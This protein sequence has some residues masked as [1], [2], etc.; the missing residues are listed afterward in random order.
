MDSTADK[1]CA[2]FDRTARDFDAIYTGQ[3]SS[4]ARWMD[5]RFRWDM[6]RRYE[7]T[8]D[9]ARDLRA[10]GADTALDVGCGSGRFCVA[11]GAQQYRRILGIDF[12]PA[13]I[14][15]AHTIAEQ[16]QVTDRCEF[17][18][19]ALEELEPKEQFDLVLSIGFFDYVAE[20]KE[21]LA[22]IR[23]LC[24]RSFVA[25]WPRS[26]SWRSRVRKVR[27]GLKH[28]PVYFFDEEE[29]RALH[30]RAGFVIDGVES[31]GE[32]YFTVATPRS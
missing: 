28:C 31:F 6:H 13:M 8:L 2:H 10:A 12:A 14:E 25:T 17:R 4:F 30:E 27:L 19:S 9:I 29:I 3:K 18:V 24:R 21:A 5:R 16:H 15:I 22:R 20:P 11:L 1:V 26:R 23:L 32:L 7:R